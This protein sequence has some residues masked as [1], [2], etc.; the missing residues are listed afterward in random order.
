MNGNSEKKRKS[1]TNLNAELLRTQINSLNA[2]FVELDTV[3]NK[4]AAAQAAC[5]DKQLQDLITL[6]EQIVALETKALGLKEIAEVN[7]VRLYE[8]VEFKEF[9]T[10]ADVYLKTLDQSTYPGPG[11]RCLYCNQPLEDSAAELLANY[12]RLLN[13]TTRQDIQRLSRERRH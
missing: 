5:S 8:S 10:A 4:I 13:D 7:S 9:I 3:V 6:N 11:D 2:Q 12:K 1:L